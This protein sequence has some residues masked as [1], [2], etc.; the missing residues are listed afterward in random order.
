[1]SKRLGFFKER[2]RQQ[3]PYTPA[4]AGTATITPSLINSNQTVVFHIDSNIIA[5]TV[6]NYSL[7]NVTNNHFVTG[8][9]LVSG[10]V[11]LDSQGNANL[12]FTYDEG[13]DANNT[14]NVNFF[15]NL[16]SQGGKNLANSNV[17]TAFQP[18]T[19]DAYADGFDT[20]TRTVYPG[21]YDPKGVPN[22]DP[23][24]SPFGITDTVDLVSANTYTFTGGVDNLS[25]VYKVVKYNLT[26]ESVFAIV[27]TNSIRVSNS[28]LSDGNIAAGATITNANGNSLIVH[29]VAHDGTDPNVAIVTAGFNSWPGGNIGNTAF[30]VG[31]SVSIGSATGTV[32][33]VDQGYTGIAPTP[34]KANANLTVTNTGADPDNTE[35]QVVIVGPG[36]GGGL[37]EAGF[38]ANA[39]STVHRYVGSGGGGGGAG[40]F[41]SANIAFTDFNTSSNSI[42]SVGQGGLSAVNLGP[43]DE[44]QPL[45]DIL[46]SSNVLTAEFYGS[47]LFV[48]GAISNTYVAG[49]GGGGAS[50]RGQ[51]YFGD[52][53]HVA[54]GGNF[55]ASGGGSAALPGQ[56]AGTTLSDV[57]SAGNISGNAGKFGFYQQTTQGIY[58]VTVIAGGGGG[59]AG[60]AGS[61]ASIG[62]SGAG[63]NGANILAGGSGGDGITNSI[64]GSN[65]IYAAGGGGGGAIAGAGG[66]SNIGG[67]G[68]SNVNIISFPTGTG[69]VT[70]FGSASPVTNTAGAPGTGSGGGGA[71]ALANL[72]LLTSEFNI[73]N[74]IP[75]GGQQRPY[76]PNSPNPEL[77]MNYPGAGGSG[78]VILRWKY[79]YKKLSL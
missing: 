68:G 1:V 7:S 15:M 50:I 64:T 58:N 2:Y 76:Y 27:N 75:V 3:F 47:G 25:A 44:L 41:L 36:G 20:I 43:Y 54:Q 37:G 60:S 53:T 55:R 12:S 56:V 14:A 9:A 49:R 26:G 48:N 73:Q 77:D 13:Y 19:F 38:V 4:P 46:D 63:F 59:G 61:N 39:T 24:T 40:G 42:V 72:A 31:D 35:L 65:V 6:L 21:G 29:R 71:G 66:S 67:I 17:V 70:E 33:S 78:T 62:I 5:N 57:G 52:R 11:T 45:P 30:S 18:V 69:L 16:Q 28:I 10:T 79:R 51:S 32:T 8:S 23:T 22:T 74:D 34:T